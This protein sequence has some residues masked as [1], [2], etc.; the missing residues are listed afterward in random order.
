MK[1]LTNVFEYFQFLKY[2]NADKFIFGI[3]DITCKY[4][5]KQMRNVRVYDIIKFLTL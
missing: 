1:L 4:I 3:I 2:L 5:A